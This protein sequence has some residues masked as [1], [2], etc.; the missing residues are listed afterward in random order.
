MA[1]PRDVSIDGM[2]FAMTTLGMAVTPSNRHEVAVL[3]VGTSVH[4][5]DNRRAKDGP[6]GA[7]IAGVVFPQGVEQGSKSW[8]GPSNRGQLSHK[9]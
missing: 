5:K 6:A 9:L 4:F 1:T 8:N 7:L 2:M 3:A